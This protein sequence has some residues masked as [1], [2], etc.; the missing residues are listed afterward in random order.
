MKALLRRHWLDL[1]LLGAALAAVLAVVLTTG[2]FTTGEQQAR[3]HHV[4]GVFRADELQRITVE[5]QGR[6]VVLERAGAGE[7]GWRIVEPVHEPAATSAVREFVHSLELARWVRRFRPG[8]VD[9][10]RFGL[11]A[12]RAVVTLEMGKQ[13]YRLVLGAPAVYRPGSAYLELGGDGVPDRGVMLVEAEVAKHLALDLEALREPRLVPY[14]PDEL[15]RIV[16]AGAGGPRRFRREQARWRFDGMQHNWL[17]D[18]RTLDTLFLALEK[19][20]AEEALGPDE[21]QRAL[22]D[23]DR[24]HVTLVPADAK[25]PRVVLEAGGHCPKRE[26]QVVVLRHEPDRRAGCVESDVMDALTRPASELVLRHL[27]TLRPDETE[28]VSIVAGE[29]H[30]ELARKDTSFVLRSPEPAPVEASAGNQRLAAILDARGTLVEGGDPKELGLA[31]PAGRVTLSSAAESEAK[32]TEETLEVSA[33][34][35][36][37]HVHVLRSTDGAVLLVDAATA[38]ALMPDATLL[39]GLELWSVEPKRI[40]KV[41]VRGG[42]ATIHLVQSSPGGFEL[43]EPKGFAVDAAMGSDLVEALAHLTAER[44]EADR[45]NGSYGLLRPE[46]EVRIETE[47]QDAGPNEHRLLVGRPTSGGAF[48]AVDRDPSIFVLPHSVLDL[49]RLLPIDR[50]APM[51]DTQAAVRID[52]RAGSETLL[53]ERVGGT[54]ERTGGTV[55][56]GPGRLQ[57]I[58]DALGSLRAE[59]AVH[60]GPARRDEGFEHPALVVEVTYEPGHDPAS[61]RT[62]FGAVDSWRDASVRYA[63]T[64]GVDATFA[65]T[66]SKLAAILGAF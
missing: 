9:R 33:P 60:L 10:A 52:L 34:D 32:V 1:T 64:D 65:V 50:S 59:A 37:G 43:I 3:E 15:A 20:T 13:R 12:P 5:R 56:V 49:L 55:A 61:R 35:A 2:R 27:F 18:R 4:L 30:W 16:L 36:Q 41:E 62:R 54:L 21:A 42:G 38:R 19:L 46:C 22:G 23:G 66:K 17:A 57:E 40:R 47:E 14:R 53:L 6:K 63:R 39:K 28:V 51:V 25:K 44:W 24:V 8:D 58:L 29:R 31:A 48:A 11:D 26:R 7:S 45:D